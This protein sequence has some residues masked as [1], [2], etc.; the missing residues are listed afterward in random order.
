MQGCEGGGQGEGVKQ[1]VGKN[2]HEQYLFRST[3]DS[4][5]KS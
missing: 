4:N 3:K 2:I 5:N 1:I